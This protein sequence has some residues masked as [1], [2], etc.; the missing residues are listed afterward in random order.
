MAH[1]SPADGSHFTSCIIFHLRKRSNT[2]NTHTGSA[3]GASRNNKKRQSHH[4]HFPCIRN[5]LLTGRRS[6]FLSARLIFYGPY[7]LVRARHE[8]CISRAS[9]YDSFGLMRCNAS[10]LFYSPCALDEKI[11]KAQK[12]LAIKLFISVE[13]AKACPRLNLRDARLL[14]Y[15]YWGSLVLGKFEWDGRNSGVQLYD[16]PN[17]RCAVN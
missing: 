4:S 8:S 17:V 10:A 12:D 9:L 7:C 2:V 13:E 11:Y 14:I 1:V 6:I 5:T 3:S 15:L 16:P